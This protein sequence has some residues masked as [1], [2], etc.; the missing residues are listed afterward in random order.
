MIT[1]ENKQNF[2]SAKGIV[3]PNNLLK[4][5]RYIPRVK[6]QGIPEHFL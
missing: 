3:S 1:N 5:K 6:N 4:I 2:P